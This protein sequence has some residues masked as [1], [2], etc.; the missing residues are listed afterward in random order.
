MKLKILE[1]PATK[2]PIQPAPGFAKKELAT[3]KLDIMQLCGFG[4]LYCSTNATTPMRVNRKAWADLAETTLGER[5]YP[6]S[7]PE[8]TM[9]WPD[10]LTKLEAQVRQH[11][12]TSRG[13]GKP[14]WGTG[15][16]LVFSMLTDGF[17]PVLVGNG[18]TE[19]ALKLVL[20]H[21]G[22]RIRVLT[23]NAVV[24][25]EKWVRLFQ[26]YPGRFV[27][28]LSCGTQ[29]GAWASKIEIGTSS[30]HARIEALHALQDAGVPTFG[31]LCPVFPDVLG[32]MGL[33]TLIALIRPHLCE[34]VWAEPFNDRANWERVREGYTPG[35]DG[36]IWLTDVYGDGFKR[37]RWSAYATQLYLRL[38]THAERFGWASKLRYLLYEDGIVAQDAPRFAG[39]RGVLLQSKPAKDGRSANTHVAALQAPVT[40][41]AS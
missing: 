32:N 30:P 4:C 7:S 16:T 38:L 34:T 39:L 6:D 12:R 20:D 29:D 18:T 3:F 41:I 22:F 10:V 23:K 11:E 27:V 37:S 33:E 21:T 1:V 15:H 13:R 36:W 31:M 24:G 19:A 9:L 25:S 40:P 5:L 2:N 28:G 26:A 14:P 35:S 17:S 8:L